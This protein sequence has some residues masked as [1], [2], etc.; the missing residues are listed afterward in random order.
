MPDDTDD[1][2]PPVT[3]APPARIDGPGQVR[4][5]VIFH[6]WEQ[7]PPHVLEAIT[8]VMGEVPEIEKTGRNERHGYNYVEESTVAETIRPLLAEAGLVVVPDI[9]GVQD[10]TVPGRNSDNRISRLKLHF[11]FMDAKDGS[12]LRVTMFSEG[13][14]PLDKAIYKALTAAEKY[15]LM[16]TFVMGTGDDPERDIGASEP[17]GGGRSSG[18]GSGSGSGNGAD[19]DCPACGGPMWDNRPKKASGEFK[20]N[21]PDFACKD[22]DGCGEKIWDYKGFLARQRFDALQEELEFTEDD[23]ADYCRAGNIPFIPD[24]D[25]AHYVR[26]VKRLEEHGMDVFAMAR[27]HLESSGYVC[28]DCGTTVEDGADTCPDCGWT[29]NGPPDDPDGGQEPPAGEGEDQATDQEPAG[30]DAPWTPD[31]WPKA[32]D[33]AEWLNRYGEDTNERLAK[34]ALWIVDER[35]RRSQGK[36][37]REFPGRYADQFQPA[38]DD[39]EDGSQEPEEQ[40]PEFSDEDVMSGEDDLPF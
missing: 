5:P 18:G 11:W 23:V 32:M 37:P 7:G 8:E 36:D 15:A 39:Q 27:D 2:E 29:R 21:A 16:K 1:R 28:P 19:V 40:G 30:D 20:P 14:D 17:A 6:D 10:Y 35:Q 34:M 12:A 13:Q 38:G 9:L 24:W 26:A 33:P 25:T 3:D 31:D 4:P 22:K